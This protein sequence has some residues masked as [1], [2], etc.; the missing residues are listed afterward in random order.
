MDN[1]NSGSRD[2]LIKKKTKGGLNLGQYAAILD[3]NQED[4]FDQN[5]DVS[6]N[7]QP[8]ANYNGDRAGL[9]DCT[10]TTDFVL[11]SLS[12]ALGLNQH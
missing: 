2:K 12:Q 6:S 1:P 3:V 5:T 4:A 9:G 8:D 10:S 7:H 11:E